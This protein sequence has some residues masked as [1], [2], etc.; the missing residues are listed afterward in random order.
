MNGVRLIWGD[1]IRESASLIRVV[2]PG[3]AAYIGDSDHC[4]EIDEL[5]INWRLS[6]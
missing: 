2:Q 5:L 4:R 3:K 1:G 6:R